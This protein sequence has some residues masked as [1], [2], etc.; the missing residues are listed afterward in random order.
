MQ[1]ILS[2]PKLLAVRAVCACVVGALLPVTRGALTPSSGVRRPAS[3]GGGVR[4]RARSERVRGCCVAALC[5]ALT[6]GVSAASKSTRTTPACVPSTPQ[7]RAWRASSWR[8]SALWTRRVMEHRGRSSGLR[9]RCLRRPY[10]DRASWSCREPDSGAAHC[11]WRSCVRRAIR[12]C[13]FQSKALHAKLGT[14]SRLRPFCHLCSLTRFHGDRRY[15]AGRAGTRLRGCGVLLAAR[16]GGQEDH[17]KPPRGHP[18]A[19]ARGEP[20]VGRTAG[21]CALLAAPGLL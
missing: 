18:S 5:S 10:R 17:L 8:R 3:D 12:G 2:D 6:R 19:R 14:L 21:G 20:C 9:R 7:C 4:S 13:R 1:R 11:E 16:R 15:V